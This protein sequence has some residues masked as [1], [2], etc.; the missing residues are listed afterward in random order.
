MNDQS[1]VDSPTTTE[2]LLA[3]GA[4]AFD[5]RCTSPS[6]AIGE[7]KGCSAVGSHSSCGTGCGLD[8]W[9]EARWGEA[10]AISFN[11]I[12][13]KLHG[14]FGSY[15]TSLWVP[16]G[17]A[18]WQQLRGTLTNMIPAAASGVGGD[19]MA[20]L[21]DPSSV[22]NKGTNAVPFNMTDRTYWINNATATAYMQQ[23]M[24]GASQVKLSTFLQTIVKSVLLSDLPDYKNHPFGPFL[25]QNRLSSRDDN[26]TMTFQPNITFPGAQC[27]AASN[28]TNVTGPIGRGSGTSGACIVARALV[29]RD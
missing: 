13:E 1:L 16:A 19:T 12:F 7:I 20:L 17:A 8:P 24:M 5:P 3:A 9:Q 10:N 11:T 29:F 28:P 26:A 23:I 14:Y 21:S 4:A 22:I 27:F 18:A 2:Y 6:L 25:G 15:P